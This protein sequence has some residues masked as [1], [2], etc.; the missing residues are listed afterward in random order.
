M[1]SSAAPIS[2]PPPL[3]NSYWVLP[4]QLLAG[5]YPADPVP[6]VTAERLA[7]LKQAGITC[8][9]DLTDAR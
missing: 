7:R 5:E 1:N 6:T 4:G 9:I 8:F 3:P 2:S